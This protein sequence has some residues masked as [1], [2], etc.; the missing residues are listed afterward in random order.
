MITL[1]NAQWKRIKVMAGFAQSLEESLQRSIDYA[2]KKNHEH[3]T[4]EHLL[5]ALIEDTDAA[6]F[7]FD[8]VQQ[9]LLED[10]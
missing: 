7:H 3:V 2:A 10:V 1:Y 5:L 6:I 9:F 8:I 4:V